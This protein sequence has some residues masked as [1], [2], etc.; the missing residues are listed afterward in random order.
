M[1]VS[2][3]GLENM[4]GK[5]VQFLQTIEAK[6]VDLHAHHCVQTNNLELLLSVTLISFV[7]FTFVFVSIFVFVFFCYGF[8]DNM[9]LGP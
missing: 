8:P 1:Q 9:L 2:L 4:S 3:P 5:N 7:L 6:K